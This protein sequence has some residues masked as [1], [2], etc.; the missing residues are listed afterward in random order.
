MASPGRRALPANVHLLRGNPSHKPLDELL[1][2]FQP[3]VEIPGCPRHLLPEAKKEW[4]RVTPE[5]ERYGL[6]ALIDRAALA[7]YCQ[8]WAEMVYHDEQLQRAHQ[9]AMRKQE[10]AAERG[11]VYS[12]GDGYTITTPNGHL[13]YSPHWV[14]KNKAAEQVHRFQETFGIGPANRNRVRPSSN[15]QLELLGDEGEPG[16]FGD[17]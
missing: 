7:L 13:G 15:R 10:E 5:L 14:M 3:Q 2:S 1:E 12:G 11:R 9:A 8:A 4:K 16:G 6:I 17:L